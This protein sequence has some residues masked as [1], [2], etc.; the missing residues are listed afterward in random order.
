MAIRRWIE[1]NLDV[2]LAR[3]GGHLFCL[4][5]APFT[6]DYW[7][8]G[9]TVFCTQKLAHLTTWGVLFHCVNRLMRGQWTAQQRTQWVDNRRPNVGA[10]RPV[11]ATISRAPG[12]HPGTPGRCLAAITSSNGVS[13]ALFA[14][15]PHGGANGCQS[16]KFNP[17]TPCPYQMI[18]SKIK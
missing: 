5:L 17:F 3:L 11:F 4:N 13:P 7:L 9:W 12:R 6:W 15:E 1:C 8:R 18:L 16:L 14:P 2:C 10:A